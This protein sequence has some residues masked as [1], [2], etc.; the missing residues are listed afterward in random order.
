LPSIAEPIIAAIAHLTKQPKE[1][2]SVS[3]RLDELGI[4]SLLRVELTALLELRFRTSLP[5][6][7]IAE[8]QT[9]G[10]LVELLAER[11]G[12][13]VPETV[14]PEDGAALVITRLLSA[15]SP[16]GSGTMDSRNPI[17]AVGSP[18]DLSVA[19]VGISALV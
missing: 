18:F 4:D 16:Q 7:A 14:A 17:P 2:I 5:E 10:E 1:R 3:S 19:Q 9:V 13:T 15:R 6:S 12:G 11:L 8:A